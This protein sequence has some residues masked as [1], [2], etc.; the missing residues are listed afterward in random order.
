MGLLG[1]RDAPMRILFA[2]SFVLA[3]LVGQVTLAVGQTHFV[4]LDAPGSF[5]ALARDNPRHFQE[6]CERIARTLR[7]PYSQLSSGARPVSGGH[8]VPAFLLTTYP[9]RRHLAFTIDDVR[10]ETFVTISA[11]AIL[12]RAAFFDARGQSAAIDAYR[13][14]VTLGSSEAAARLANIYENGL[15]GV[16]RDS[17]EAQKWRNAVKGPRSSARVPIDDSSNR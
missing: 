6:V 1:I 15:L 12:Q 3:F 4:D 7:H 10:Y 17:V 8:E 14:A 13:G 9:P 16:P 5:E 11:N 2:T